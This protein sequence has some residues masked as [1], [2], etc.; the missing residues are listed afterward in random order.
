VTDQQHRSVIIGDDLLQ[1]VERLKVKVVGR[2]I[3]DEKVRFPGKFAC[4]K[5][6]RTLAPRQ[7]ANVRIGDGGVEEKI[8]QISLD[9]LLD[10][11]DLDPVA[12]IGKD[13][14]HL[15]LRREKTSL[16]VDDDAV[17]RRSEG[18]APFVGSDLAGQ[19]LQQ[20]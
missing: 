4:E 1:E 8:L 11:A 16:L 15:L 14:P 9:R 20:G 18:D 6:P 10:P 12:P 19:Q 13:V 17:E 3:E 5:K 2:L 7:C